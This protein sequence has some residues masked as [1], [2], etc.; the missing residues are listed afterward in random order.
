[1]VK[2]KKE[3]TKIKK[4]SEKSDKN[5]EIYNKKTETHKIDEDN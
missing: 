3:I 4:R 5:K 1:M 2:E